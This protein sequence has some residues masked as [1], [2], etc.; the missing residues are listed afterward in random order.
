MNPFLNRLKE[1]FRKL[2][3]ALLQKGFYILWSLVIPLVTIVAGQGLEMLEHLVENGGVFHFVTLVFI[4]TTIGYTLW[5]VPVPIIHIFRRLIF[6]KNNNPE[7]NNIS[8]FKDSVIYLNNYEDNLPIRFFSVL[9][10]IIFTLAISISSS[11]YLPSNYHAYFK[12]VIF[13]I[14]AF[15]LLS[16]YFFPPVL[17]G[18]SMFLHRMLNI[19][20]LQNTIR[21]LIRKKDFSNETEKENYIRIS[22]YNILNYSFYLLWIIL[23][24]VLTYIFNNWMNGNKTYIPYVV[25]TT[26]I[27]LVTLFTYWH[28]CMMYYV[29]NSLYYYSKQEIK[30]YFIGHAKNIALANEIRKKHEAYAL[31]HSYRITKINYWILISQ[32]LFFTICMFLLSQYNNI[33]YFSPLFILVCC[34]NLFLL[35]FDAFY[36]Y[37]LSLIGIYKNKIEE[38]NIVQT[39][40]TFWDVK[41]KNRLNWSKILLVIGA[42]LFWVIFISLESNKHR[43]RINVVNDSE[44]Y[45]NPDDRMDLKSYYNQWMSYDTARKTIFLIA[46]Q[47]GGSRAAAWTHMNLN[48]I[49]TAFVLMK[50]TFAFST[51][52]GSSVGISMKLAEWRLETVMGNTNPVKYNSDTLKDLYCYNYFSNSFYGIMM[53]DLKEHWLQ[54]W[55]SFFGNK[56]LYDID[57]N[58]RLQKEEYK[59]FEKVFLKNIDATKKAIAKYILKNH[60]EGDYLSFNY[61]KDSFVAKHFKKASQPLFFINTTQVQRG[62]RCVFYPI[63]PDKDFYPYDVYKKIKYPECNPYKTNNKKVNVNIP[64]QTAVCQ[65]QAV[66]VLNSMNYVNSFGNL[67]DGGVAENSG[68]GNIYMIY[69]KLREENICDSNV[70]IVV[71]FLQNSEL[72]RSIKC[73]D[74]KNSSALS[75]AFSAIF[76]AG[77]TSYSAYWKNMLQNIVLEK[78]KYQPKENQDKFYVVKLSKEII[79]GRILNNSTIYKMHEE[80]EKD[81]VNKQIKK[82][83][84]EMLLQPSALQYF[85]F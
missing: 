67:C 82:I 26:T 60:F 55:K 27:V 4:F 56:S 62:D 81:T 47:G 8:I 2:A 70:R 48:Y 74:V 33:G 23:F 72:D 65:S 58:Y 44:P 40:N 76:N 22:L 75:G 52:S 61:P 46:G 63:N 79:L 25:R 80:L 29:E 77:L 32:V 71:I 36:K 69:K 6:K 35:F 10:L 73:T 49:D 30:N 38:N 12:F 11:I 7:I 21:K 18:I 59:G 19:K 15:W 13:G 34:F 24:A 43:I 17:R 1:F 50:N 9:P 54:N 16:Y 68:C 3:N 85:Q 66:P 14:I 45:Y 57:R 51:A 53:G 5:I 64:L 84:T 39:T 20:F 31:H 42:I 83:T 78:S 28:Y 37:P 41:L